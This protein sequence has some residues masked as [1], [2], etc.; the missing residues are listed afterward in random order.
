MTDIIFGF[1]TLTKI[2]RYWWNDVISSFGACFAQMY[3][4]HSLG[5]IHSL[6]LLI[7]WIA[8]LL[9]GFLSDILLQLQIKQFLLLVPCAG[10]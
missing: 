6:I 10:Y 8:L 3:F 1:V 9:Y 4:V 7:I 2:A 5:A